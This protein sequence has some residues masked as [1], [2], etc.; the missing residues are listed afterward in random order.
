MPPSGRPGREIAAMARR[1]GNPE[2]VSNARF[3]ARAPRPPL[4]GPA[5]LA[6]AAAAGQR[7]PRGPHRG[8]AHRALVRPGG[9]VRRGAV[10]NAGGGRKQAKRS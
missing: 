5:V 6:L 7:Q 1:K 3:A 4:R 10:L 2:T 9:D 8:Q